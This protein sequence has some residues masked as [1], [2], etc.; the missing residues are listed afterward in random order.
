MAI[1][2]VSHEYEIKSLE[3]QK[4]IINIY[5][6]LIRLG[7]KFAI[8]KLSYYLI[9]ILRLVKLKFKISFRFLTDMLRWV[10]LSVNGQ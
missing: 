7:H 10:Y 1:Y 2:M 5:V 9:L 3:T 4:P 8:I 6:L